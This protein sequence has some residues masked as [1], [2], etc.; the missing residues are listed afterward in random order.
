MAKKSEKVPPPPR[1]RYKSRATL[2]RSFET[3]ITVVQGCVGGDTRD[4]PRRERRRDGKTK[5]KSLTNRPT[6]SHHRRAGPADLRSGHTH[7]SLSCSFACD[8]IIDSRSMPLW[9][10]RIPENIEG[11]IPPPPP[12]PPP[13]PTDTDPWLSSAFSPAPSPGPPPLRFFTRPTPPP[14]ACT[15]SMAA[16]EAEAPG[17]TTVGEREPP[18]MEDR[19]LSDIERP[20][21]STCLRPCGG[22]TGSR[23]CGL[24]CCCC[25]CCCTLSAELP[26]DASTAFILGFDRL[27]DD[28]VF[29]PPALPIPDESP[30]PSLLSFP[31]GVLPSFESRRKYFCACVRTWVAFRVPTW[32]AMALTFLEP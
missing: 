16:E 14:E 26:P 9:F 1:D 13:P 19:S 30:G 27:G 8:A 25:C 7:S 2:A 10:R 11:L 20:H 6:I 32:P 24:R 22:S 17:S 21:E 18:P 31:G 5:R 28:A 29:D 23:P 15:P 3:I 4:K 12:P